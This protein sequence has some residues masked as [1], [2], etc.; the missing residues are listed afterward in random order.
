MAQSLLYVA[1]SITASAVPKDVCE[2]SAD[3]EH[4]TA[5]SFGIGDARLLSDRAYIKPVSRSTRDFLVH[6]SSITIEAQNALLKL[7]EDPPESAVFHVIL[8]R[9]DML[10]PTLRSRLLLV[11]RE[12]SVIDRDVMRA[13]LAM[14]Y[15]ERMDEIASRTKAKDAAWIEE[16]V[17]GAEA[18]AE[19]IKGGAKARVLKSVVFVRQYFS[20]RSAAKKMLLEE[21]ALSL[22]TIKSKQTA[23]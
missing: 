16:V 10:L 12:E 4:F 11:S 18:Y 17:A 8:S 6:F 22:P 5:D 20:A 13:F 7:F 3:I 21:L 14:S 19:H 15:G 2:Q 9:E 1:R 23:T